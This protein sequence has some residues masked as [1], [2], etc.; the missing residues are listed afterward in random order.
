VGAVDA[1]AKT[2]TLATTAGTWDVGSAVKG[3]LKAQ[4][5]T[6]TPNSDVI[7]NVGGTAAAPVLTFATAKDLNYFAANDVVQVITAADANTKAFRYWRLQIE[8]VTMLHDPSSAYRFLLMEDGTEFELERSHP[9]NCSDQ[10]TIMSY[11]SPPKLGSSVLAPG[12]TYG[13]S[14]GTV[15]KYLIVDFGTPR[16]VLSAGGYN[17]YSVAAR[18]AMASLSGSNDQATWTEIARAEI[19]S[20]L[21]CG[22]YYIGGNTPP[23]LVKVASVN[24]GAKQITVSAGGKWKAAD[25]TG[26]QAAGQDHLQLP[27]RTV[28]AA[29][30]KLYCKL[31]AAGAVS[32]L[33]SADPGFTAWTPAGTGPYTGTV[34]FPATLPSGADPDT[35][36]PAGTT[37][38]VEVEA[39]NTSG[40]DSAKSNTVTPA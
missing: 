27:T 31:D 17:V 6:V 16:V 3:P 9:D 5:V 10:G 32:D 33:Q 38:T 39:S 14:S 28:P 34:T 4:I 2:I 12:V 22:K 13:G 35:D 36:L 21:A 40:S 24:I 11:N 7:T 19:K 1:T 25:G 30:V 37:I 15:P 29:N 20:D 18:G 8:S 23:V 26:D